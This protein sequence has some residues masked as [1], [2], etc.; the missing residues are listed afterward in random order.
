[1][2]VSAQAAKERESSV[3]QARGKAHHRHWSSRS[4]RERVLQ[5]VR[6]WPATREDA[7]AVEGGV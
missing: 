7:R 3:G 4:A 2:Q 5:R 6:H 1:M